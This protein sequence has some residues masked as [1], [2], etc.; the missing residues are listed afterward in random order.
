MN[1]DLSKSPRLYVSADLSAGANVVLPDTQAHYLKNVMRAE[2]GSAVRLFNGRD[3]EWR[4]IIDTLDKKKAALA[5]KAQTRAQSPARRQ[6]HLLFAPI[7]K[8]RMEWLIEKA[9]EL[10]ATDIHPVITNHTEVRDINAERTRAQ[11]IE[12]AEQCE[13]LDIPQ[14]H[15]IMQLKS[16]LGAWAQNIPILVGL[17]RADAPLLKNT[18]PETGPLAFL[19]GPEGGF[20]TEEREYPGNLPFLKPV[21]LGPDILRAETAAAYVLVAAHL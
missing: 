13:R 4:G 12:A 20:S 2:A 19:I 10:G 11:I 18:L 6:V 3:G 7:K 8:A 1:S 17:E 9:V 5:L 14:L 16:K 21:S 15:D